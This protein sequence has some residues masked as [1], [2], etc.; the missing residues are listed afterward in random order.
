MVLEFHLS[1]SLSL[2][3]VW[4]GGVPGEIGQKEK[5]RLG[6]YLEIKETT[7]NFTKIIHTYLYVCTLFELDLC[8]RLSIYIVNNTFDI[9]V[10]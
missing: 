3:I 5:Q 7:Y 9:T 2:S 1:L 4:G 6:T 10:S 8:S